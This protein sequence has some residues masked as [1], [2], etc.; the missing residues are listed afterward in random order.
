LI[1]DI[2]PNA[3]VGLS[4]HI[5]IHLS[6]SLSFDTPVFISSTHNSIMAASNYFDK[7]SFGDI[8]G[9]FGDFRKANWSNIL[10]F[11]SF[12]DWIVLFND[13]SD[14]DSYWAR[15]C[16]TILYIVNVSTPLGDVI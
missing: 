6:I 9:D 7:L 16:E 8:I 5:S 10:L 13:C 15:F 4:D 1:S 3:P 12:I 11:V 2:A 14:A